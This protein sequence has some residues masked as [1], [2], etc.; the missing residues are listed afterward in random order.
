MFEG[1]LE[2]I[3]KQ[4]LYRSLR[5]VE[6][7]Q[8]PRVQI[9]GREMICLASN[10]YLGL[11]AHPALKE[12]ACGAAD[13]YGTGSGASRLL[14]GTSIL[15]TGLEEQISEFLGCEAA[16]LFNTGYT[17]NIG[18]LSALCREG[19]LILSDALNHASIVDGCRL[20]RA[21]K[22]VYNHL[23]YNGLEEK[24]KASHKYK[25]RW[26]VTESLFSMGGDLAPLP[27]L[28]ELA[29]RYGAHIFLDEAHA[30]GVMGEHGK[31]CAAHFGVDDR[32][33]VRMGTLGK[34]FGSFGAFVAGSREIIDLLINCS[35]PLIY[36]TAL[37]PPVLAASGA[38]LKLV[39]ESEGDLLRERLF[40]NA[41]M[42]VQRFREIGFDEIS[43]QSQIIPLVLGSVHKAL[44]VS[45]GLDEGGVF[46]PAIRP[47][48]VPEGE[49]RIR[50]SVMASHSADDL[51]RVVSVMKKIV[52]PH[53]RGAEG[54][55]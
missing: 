40:S 33:T 28:V 46:A 15:H 34:A 12:A 10:D 47:P 55:E 9:G 20:S 35:R 54:A 17:A 43:D 26:I 11:A 45:K 22:E 5:T 24:L 30:V 25:R 16:L 53:R 49:A 51:E 38:A 18:L 8:G 6:S 41:M 31:G 2:I 19:D 3:Q 13:R 7:G 14:S 4:G 50:F 23:D 29:E 32:I 48:T 21:D 42:L 36:S 39:R 44:E 27:D 1:E 52:R 37:P